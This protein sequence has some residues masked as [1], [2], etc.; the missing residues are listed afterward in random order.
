MKE[1]LANYAHDAWAGWMRYLFEKSTENTDGT[2]TIPKWAVDRW[3]R[4]MITPYIELPEEEKQSDREEADIMMEIFNAN[5]NHA[6]NALQ[7][8]RTI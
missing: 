6:E 3:K 4:Q 1:D 8:L 2:V 7:R 5:Q